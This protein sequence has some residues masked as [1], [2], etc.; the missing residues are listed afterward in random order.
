MSAT[1]PQR[2]EI[3]WAAVPYAFAEP[4]RSPDWDGGIAFSEVVRRVRGQRDRVAAVVPLKVR[5]VLILHGWEHAAQESYAVL[6][7][8]RLEVLGEPHRR[9]VRAGGDP[10]L[11]HLAGRYAGRE[12]AVMVRGIARIHASA[13]DT[14]SL[15]RI[16]GAELR[17]VGE[18]V[19]GALDLDLDGLIERC[20]EAALAD[21]A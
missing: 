9:L 11:V 12:R 6:R 8:K 18:G 2:G 1:L 20:V 19:A 21:L 10:G 15:G 16:S 3:R 14:V 17:A 5:P 13:V 7:T 4:F